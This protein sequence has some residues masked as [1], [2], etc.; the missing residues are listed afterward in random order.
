MAKKKRG[1]PPKAPGEK[2]VG[3]IPVRCKPAEKA[4]IEAAA[5]AASLDTSSWCRMILLET[6]RDGK[7]R[8]GQ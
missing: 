8:K 4:E 1:A 2:K 3:I 6:A 7:K 5:T